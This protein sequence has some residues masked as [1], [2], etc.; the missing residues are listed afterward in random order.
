MPQLDP[1]FEALKSVSRTK[2]RQPTAVEAEPEDQDSF[3]ARAG[4]TVGNAGLSGLAAA[5]NLLDLPGSMVRDVLGG[6]NPIDQLLT[7]FSDKDSA[8]NSTRIGGRDLLR[9]HGMVGDE[10][11]WGN[12]GGGLAAEIALDPTTYLTLGASALGKGGKIAKAAGLLDDVARVGAT[13]A[14]RTAGYMGAKRAS[15]TTSLKDLIDDAVQTGG[16]EGARR[17]QDATEKFAKSTEHLDSVPVKVSK[18][19]AGNFTRTGGAYD[20]LGGL[21][22]FGA[23]FMD[24]SAVV[25]TGKFSQGVADV[26]DT[27]GRAARFAAIPGTSIRPVNDIINLFDVTSGGKNTPETVALSKQAFRQKEL[28]DA[29]ARL[30][31]AQLTTE[32]QKHNKAVEATAWALDGPERTRFLA[33]ATEAFGPEQAAKNVATMD[34]RAKE[35]TTRADQPDINSIDDFYRGKRAVANSDPSRLGLGAMLQDD[36][37]DAMRQTLLD[38]VDADLRRQKPRAEAGAPHVGSIDDQSELGGYRQAI[39]ADDYLRVGKG[40]R[41]N[42]LDTSPTMRQDIGPNTLFQDGATDAMREELLRSVDDSLRPNNGRIAPHIGTLESEDLRQRRINDVMAGPKAAA[43]EMGR[44][45]QLRDDYK[46]AYQ[47]HRASLPADERKTL[48]ALMDAGGYVSGGEYKTPGESYVAQ[49]LNEHYPT[50]GL[51]WDGLADFADGKMPLED[52]ARLNRLP[53]SANTVT[54]LKEIPQLN[55]DVTKAHFKYIDADFAK[56]RLKRPIDPN[57]IEL[58]PIT[59]PLAPKLTRGMRQDINSRGLMQSD[60]GFNP[61][62]AVEFNPANPR[63]AVIHAF[64]AKNAS[65]FAHEVGHIFR[66]TLDTDLM[67]RAAKDLSVADINAWTREEE[68]LFATQ[69]ERY[70]RDGKAPTEALRSVF[71]KFKEWMLSVYRAVV[72]TPLDKEISPELKNVFDEM[73]GGGARKGAKPK[74][75]LTDDLIR[76][77]MEFPAKRAQLLQ[78]PTLS[79]P[80]QKLLG[81]IPGEL[82]AQPREAA[83]IGVPRSPIDDPLVAAG[84]QNY[85]PRHMPTGA[86]PQT[87]GPKK[88]F[89]AMTAEAKQRQPFLKGIKGGTTDLRSVL[90]D[91]ELHAAVDDS[92]DNGAAL[93]KKKY[94]NIIPPT[95][96]DDAGN[97]ADRYAA[98]SGMLKG[99]PDEIRKAG[100]FANTPLADLE[101]ARRGYATS[102]SNAKMLAEFLGQ[103]GI[104]NRVS[105]A[106]AKGTMTVGDLLESLN[107]KS[108]DEKEGFLKEI[109]RSLYGVDVSSYA[110]NE[111]RQQLADIK[112]LRIKNELAKDLA[113]GLTGGDVPE[114]AKGLLGMFDKATNLFKGSV[115]SP[116]P[117]FHFRNRTGGLFQNLISGTHSTRSV[118]DANAILTGRVVKGAKDIP[119]A[120]QALEAKGITGDAITDEN[121]TEALR[122]LVAAYEVT[123]PGQGIGAAVVDGVAQGTTQAD[124]ASRLPGNE[125]FSWQDIAETAAGVKGK[126]TWKPWRAKVRGVNADETTFAP[127]AAGEKVGNYVEGQNRIAPFIEQ[128]RRGIAPEVAAKNVQDAHVGYAGKHYTPFEREVMQ[129]FA[130]FFKFQKGQ[131]KF[132]AKELSEKPGGRLAQTI[133]G[134]NSLQ[135]SDEP[136]PEHIADTAAVPVQEDGLGAVLGM[137]KDGSQRFLTGLGLPFEDTLQFAGKGPQDLALEVLGRSNPY[138]TLPLEAATGQVFFQRGPDGGRPLEDTDPLLGRIASNLTGGKEPVRYKNDRFVD[139][140]LSHSPLSRAVTTLR[141]AT[142]PR[143]RNVGGAM[144]LLTGVRVSDVSEQKQ[145]QVLQA[146]VYKLMRELGGKVFTRAFVPEGRQEAMTAAEKKKVAEMEALLNELAKR[147]KARKG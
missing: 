51:E 87:T 88:P 26:M 142:D 131:A 114:Q 104:L 39:G 48:D 62:G 9:K 67:N 105:G 47:A 28:D 107:L 138:L 80:L 63:E 45:R 34:A 46:R 37:R 121:A 106:D 91:P 73:L 145:D 30:K 20:P 8:G 3:F 5:G 81:D 43:E 50:R 29:A 41:R 101:G 134:V 85:F 102:M 64:K 100:V 13:K 140:L 66:R 111:A 55:M 137:P 130:P 16:E 128:L 103:K 42:A 109:L 95:Y 54:F 113:T 97:T 84:L 98:I 94:G 36:P 116:F 132:V 71:A 12:W 56:E 127:F 144:N 117:S 40:G 129:R 65:T 44:T 57:R 124:L 119:A 108:G 6:E 96:V 35:M 59:D 72:G 79:G 24:P 68:E 77:A 78:N 143:K 122:E 83:K 136:I 2:R 112:N 123:G 125:P 7:P 15:L 4:K 93:L 19:S 147:A 89:D 1:V 70:L 110:T 126:G 61:R 75:A 120:Q 118:G 21:M 11:T 146:Q 23:P 33:E 141:T 18:D 99:M 32:T 135:Q 31:T 49:L 14:G 82:D 133:R 86:V 60:G 74:G 69:Y 90:A 25:G 53:I 52:F 139:Q 92:I 17:A 38:S 58:P 27:A 10:D 115:T 76:D 22:G